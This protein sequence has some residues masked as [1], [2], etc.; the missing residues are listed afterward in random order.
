[1]N[2][3]KYYRLKFHPRPLTQDELA[4]LVGVHRNRISLYEIGA[5][6]P[7]GPILFRIAIALNVLPEILYKDYCDRERKRMLE[8]KKRMKLFGSLD[9]Y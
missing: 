1:M 6:F 5:V 4:K 3:I 2:N 8:M 9:Y 7:S